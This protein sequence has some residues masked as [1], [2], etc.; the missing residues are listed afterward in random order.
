MW[1][2]AVVTPFTDTLTVRVDGTVV[3]TYTEPAV[4]ETGYTLRTIPLNFGTDRQSHGAVQLPRADDPGVANF[5]V[6]NVSLLA[7]GVCAT[8][9][10]S[11]SPSTS[12]SPTPTGEYD[13]DDNSHRRRHR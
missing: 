12:P 13:D 7:G 11:P 4:A 8:P 3:Q 2:G 9:T 10:P 1:I 6:D 5:S